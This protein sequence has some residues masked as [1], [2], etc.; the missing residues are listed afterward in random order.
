[1]II[2]SDWGLLRE[3]A[4]AVGTGIVSTHLAGIGGGAASWSGRTV[5]CGET[6]EE[7]FGRPR[8]NWALGRGF[9]FHR[10][11]ERFKAMIAIFAVKFVNRHNHSLLEIQSLRS[12]GEEIT[13]ARAIVKAYIINT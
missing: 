7:L 2:S 10:G 11:D 8:A 1:M 3:G 13:F 6:A 12:P 4:G 5:M 9:A